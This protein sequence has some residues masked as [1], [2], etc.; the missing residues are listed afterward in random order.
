MLIENHCAVTQLLELGFGK[1]D[2]CVQ[3][4]IAS[5]IKDPKELLGKRITTSFSTVA[6]R[7][8][9]ALGRCLFI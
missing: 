5:G 9:Q 4:P 1:C 6:K 8:F 7:Y 2:L 3:V